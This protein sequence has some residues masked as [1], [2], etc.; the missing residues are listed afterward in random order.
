MATNEELSNLFVYDRCFSYRD[1]SYT[2]QRKDENIL[3]TKF[4]KI[5]KIIDAR[6]IKEKCILLILQDRG[7][8]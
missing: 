6:N 7:V 1:W 3:I 2:L 5:E 4:V 8:L